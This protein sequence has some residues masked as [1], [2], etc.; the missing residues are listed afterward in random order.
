[1]RPAGDG[2]PASAAVLALP[3]DVAALPGGGFG[4]LDAGKLRIVGTD[5]VIR[6]AGAPPAVAIATDPTGL[7]LLDSTGHVWRR[8]AD[9]ALTAVA[10]LGTERAGITPYLPVAGDPF[11]AGEPSA[12]DVIAS[13]DGGVLLA[14]DF[15]VHYVPPAVPS[16][17]AVAIRPATRVPSRGLTVSV[18][19]TAP[20]QLRIGVWRGGRR[21]ALVT[22]QVPAGDAA[23]PIPDVHVGGQ[24]RIHVQAADHDDIAAAS[25]FVLVGGR[26]PVAYAR[27]FL[28]GRLNLLEAYDDFEHVTLR[29]RRLGIGRVDCAMRTDRGRCAGIASLRV[30]RD[31]TLTLWSYD[32]G[33]RCRFDR[34]R[35]EPPTRRGPGV[36]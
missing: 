5:G 30:E 19:T 13:P 25:A 31:G 21:A 34:A 6:S 24:Y 14:A 2:G 29:C 23:I 22:I 10:N 3:T 11:A 9:G 18:T 36:L 28:R 35:G 17:L 1:V 20:S 26:L 16:R 32:G 12:T 4:V 15:A 7:L 27:D 8:T 33:R